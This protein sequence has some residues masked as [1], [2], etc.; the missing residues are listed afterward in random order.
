MQCMGSIN[1]QSRI[2][3]LRL[4]YVLITDAFYQSLCVQQ[5]LVLLL[6]TKVSPTAYRSGGLIRRLNTTRNHP[7]YNKAVPFHFRNNINLSFVF[8]RMPQHH[9]SI[10]PQ[11][12]PYQV[13]SRGSIPHKREIP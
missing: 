5:E 2:F 3:V 10:L 11:R 7:I 12:F 6:N 8:P 9:L 1:I 13:R 4:R